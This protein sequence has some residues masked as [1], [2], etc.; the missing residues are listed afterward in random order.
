[1]LIGVPKE[2]KTQ[3]NR[4]GLTPG[5]V[6]EFL[7]H[8]H[9]VII[10]TTAG[11]GIGLSDDDY[12]NAGAEIVGSAAEVFER[13]D[14]VIKVKEPI[15]P[16]YQYFR[17]D[18]ILY[19]YLHLAAVPELTTALLES[20][21]KGI[22]YETI[23]DPSGALPLLRP[24]SEIAGRMSVQVG[25]ASLQKENGGK[26]VL[27]GG[28][29]GTRRGR[30]T[31]IGGG[32][33]GTAAARIAIGMGALDKPTGLKLAVHIWAQEAGDYLTLCDDLPRLP[34]SNHGLTMQERV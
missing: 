28:V 29:P 7:H 15:A 31:V 5:S 32:V 8:G 18:L 12:R 16:E 26:G 1:M 4:V 11:N 33:V 2:I 25:A 30:V 20:Q 22:A 27:L 19:T 9:Q 14:M 3:E 23:T 17:K 6:Q 24:M 21:V 10:E 34:D 13:A